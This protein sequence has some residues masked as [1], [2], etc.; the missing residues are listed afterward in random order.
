MPK[1]KICDGVMKMDVVLF[2][3][4]LTNSIFEEA[5][6]AVMTADVV[7]VVGT[8]LTVRTINLFCIT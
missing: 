3:E 6:A 7:L 5:M 1:C 8:S 2:G 4:A